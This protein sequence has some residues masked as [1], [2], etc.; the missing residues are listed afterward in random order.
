[1]WKWE[2]VVYLLSNT[3]RMNPFFA[4][5]YD[6]TRAHT[7]IKLLRE[8]I[9]E[10]ETLIKEIEALCNHTDDTGSALL[11]SKDGTYKFCKYCLQKSEIQNH[12]L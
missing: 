4:R 11:T 6:W 7:D 12:A 3:E 9:Q 2:F 5:S 1:M 10:K 8:E